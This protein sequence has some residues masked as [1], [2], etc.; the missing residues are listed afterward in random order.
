MLLRTKELMQSF[1]HATLGVKIHH[2]L[3]AA[4]AT[5]EKRK[6]QKGSVSTS[7][8]HLSLDEILLN[9][10]N[11]PLIISKKLF[12]QSTTSSLLVNKQLHYAHGLGV[13]NRWLFFRTI[14][15][16]HDP[17]VHL[18]ANTLRRTSRYSTEVKKAK[19]T[20]PVPLRAIL[21][22]RLLGCLCLQSCRGR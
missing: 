16:K 6:Q 1:P 21:S 12:L 9:S 14:F 8:L 2:P 17:T 15:V 11:L 4:P 13:V 19:S 20:L 7:C 3:S 10:K 5:A 18:A 22:V